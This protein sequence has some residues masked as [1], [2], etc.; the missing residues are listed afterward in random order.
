MHSVVGT[1]MYK[2]QM[3]LVYNL[4]FGEKRS[5]RSQLLDKLRLWR[6]VLNAEDAKKDMPAALRSRRSMRPGRDR[7]NTRC[8]RNQTLRCRYRGNGANPMVLLINP[9][10]EHRR[11]YRLRLCDA[12]SA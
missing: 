1:T 11:A 2:R 7:V 4:G 5:K 8:K 12:M 6:G 9:A 3:P 10:Q